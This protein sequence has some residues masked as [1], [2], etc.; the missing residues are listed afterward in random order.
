MKQECTLVQWKCN[1]MVTSACRHPI[2]EKRKQQKPVQFIFLFTT[3]VQ[4]MW[5]YQWFLLC[6]IA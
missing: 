5:P 2:T 6:H 3:A 4:N 1:K